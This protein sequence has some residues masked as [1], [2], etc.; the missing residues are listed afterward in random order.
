MT[1]KLT[2]VGIPMGREEL[3][4]NQKDAASLKIDYTQPIGKNIN[5][6]TGYQGYSQWFDNKFSNGDESV[7]TRFHYRE[8]RQ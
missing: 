4:T 7:S 8:I 3:N 6:S 2:K 1:D 5:A